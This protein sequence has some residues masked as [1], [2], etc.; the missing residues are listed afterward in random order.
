M[1]PIVSVRKDHTFVPAWVTAFL[2]GGNSC[3]NNLRLLKQLTIN[4]IEQ[5]MLS[6]TER[7]DLLAA[8]WPRW[9]AYVDWLL[10]QQQVEASVQGHSC[11][12]A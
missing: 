5:S 7:Q 12:I 9:D 10:T 1:L 11:E 6:A 8:W 3:F 4:S 2:L